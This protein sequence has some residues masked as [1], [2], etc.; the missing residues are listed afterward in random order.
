MK[1]SKQ[2]KRP[3]VDWGRKFSK[4]LMEGILDLAYRTN[5]DLGRM[6]FDDACQTSREHVESCDVVFAVW[7][8]EQEDDVFGVKCV[9]GAGIEGL[10]IT[11]ALLVESKEVADLIERQIESWRAFELTMSG[12]R[13]H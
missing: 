3:P 10:G 4:K 8:H 1:P 9:K 7:P 5:E 11:G 12:I 13:L 6:S 2:S